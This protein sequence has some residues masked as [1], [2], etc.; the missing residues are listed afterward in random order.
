MDVDGRG[1]EV[2]VKITM[3]SE[4]MFGCVESGDGK[5]RIGKAID[6]ILEQTKKCPNVKIIFT[7]GA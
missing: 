1:I 4:Q 2:T 3:T 7:D 6:M 5:R